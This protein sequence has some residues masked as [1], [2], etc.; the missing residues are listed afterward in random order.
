[1]TVQ[2]DARGLQALIRATPERL[3]RAVM[4]AATEINSEIV[5]SF[6][7]S[8]SS[9]GEPPG[10]DTGALRASMRA[11]KMKRRFTARVATSIDYAPYLEFGTERMAARPFF[12]PVMER[13]RGER[14]S[15]FLNDFLSDYLKEFEGL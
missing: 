4:A 5:T 3:D 9:P 8:P 13:W 7:T 2:I 1:M 6:G 12:S 14:W 15:Q 10:V 11:V